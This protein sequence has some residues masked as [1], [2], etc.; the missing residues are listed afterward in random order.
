MEIKTEPWVSVTIVFVDGKKL[1]GN[2]RDDSVVPDF[3][4]NPTGD[5]VM[6]RVIEKF[7]GFIKTPIARASVSILYKIELVEFN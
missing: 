6:K 2:Y 3:L 4:E 1:K 5:G 7:R